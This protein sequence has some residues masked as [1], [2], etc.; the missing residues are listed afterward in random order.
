MITSLT[1]WQATDGT[2]FPTED[3]AIRYERKQSV[4]DFLEIKAAVFTSKDAQDLVLLILNYLAQ[5]GSPVKIDY[6]NSPEPKNAKA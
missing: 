2:Q 1:V 6:L 4:L 3:D 5:P